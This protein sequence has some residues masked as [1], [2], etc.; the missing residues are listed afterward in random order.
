MTVI[1][2][3]AGLIAAAVLGFWFGRHRD[4]ISRREPDARATSLA[5]FAVDVQA[6][7]ERERALIAR[8]LHDQLGGI[9]VAS[10]MDIDLISRRLVTDDGPMKTKL[11]QVSAALDAGLALKRRLVERL[12]PSILDHLGLYAAL[13]WQLGE[14][15]AAAGRECTARVP[16]GD[17]GFSADAAITVYRVAEQAIAKALACSETSLVEL[18]AVATSDALEL[19]ITDDGGPPGDSATRPVEGS[20]LTA[21][22]YRAESLGGACR[23]ERHPDGGT[24]ICI[25]FPLSRLAARGND[26]RSPSG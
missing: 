18:D 6:S 19:T 15:C 10:K 14:L 21:L 24:R 7:T 5:A 11:A 12:H 2:T 3:L 22:T 4:K 1:A 13:Q 8:E 9:F 23:A 16:D 20:W 25:R 26:E 17:P